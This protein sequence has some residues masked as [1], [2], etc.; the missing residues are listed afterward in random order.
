MKL[1]SRQFRGY[2]S[3]FRRNSILKDLWNHRR[4]SSPTIPTEPGHQLMETPNFQRACLSEARLSRVEYKP[5]HVGQPLY[6]LTFKLG[7]WSMSCDAR[8][9]KKKENVCNHDYGS[10]I[11]FLLISNIVGYSI[12]RVSLLAFRG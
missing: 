8:R 4:E 2:I 6:I 3:L 5:G 1:Q 9:S 7:F 11:S 12:F 10:L